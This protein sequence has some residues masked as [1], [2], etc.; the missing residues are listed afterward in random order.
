MKNEVL[1][2]LFSVWNS[3]IGILR[4]IEDIELIKLDKFKAI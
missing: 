4:F 2:A 3:S 1:G